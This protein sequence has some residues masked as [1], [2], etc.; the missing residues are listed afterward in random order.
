MVLD[1]PTLLFD[2]VTEW[3]DPDGKPAFEGGTI[4]IE[5]LRE[6]PITILREAAE[7]VWQEHVRVE[8]RKAD[9]KTRRGN[10]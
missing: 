9:A 2:A 7:V 8:T 3:K 5:R 1:F 6:V 10:S 4:T